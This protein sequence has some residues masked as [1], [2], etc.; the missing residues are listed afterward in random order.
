VADG[1]L[2]R[3]SRRKLDLKDGKPVPQEPEPL[4]GPTSAVAAPGQR[5][6]STGVSEPATAGAPEPRPSP[7]ME[8]VTALTRESDYSGFVGGH[9]DPQVRN[10][11]MKKLFADPHYNIMDRLDTYIDDYSQPDPIPPAMLRQL[12]SAKFLR[13]FD[14]DEDAEK[15]APAKGRDDADR[16][17][18]QDMAQSGHLNELPSQPGA[19][20]PV[21]SQ[22]DH[23]DPDLRLQQDHAPPGESPGSGAR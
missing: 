11:A 12:A 9:V 8:D 20:A 17:P 1:F 22:T 14:D 6:A 19:A 23:A 2:G 5:A 15:P 16:P 3:W 13:L 4:A 21:P 18:A 10:A 7:T